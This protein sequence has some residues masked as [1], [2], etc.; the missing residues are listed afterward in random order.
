MSIDNAHAILI[1][2]HGWWVANA[3][4]AH[5]HCFWKQVLGGINAWGNVSFTC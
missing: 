5:F 2:I 3:G 4:E 1:Q